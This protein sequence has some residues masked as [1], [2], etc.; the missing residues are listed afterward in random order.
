MHTVSRKQPKPSGQGKCE[1]SRSSSHRLDSSYARCSCTSQHAGHVR[2]TFGVVVVVT[3]LTECRNVTR[4]HCMLRCIWW[5]H[6]TFTYIIRV[7]VGMI[8]L[9]RAVALS[10]TSGLPNAGCT[11]ASICCCVT[12]G[13]RSTLLL[14]QKLLTAGI[15][16]EAQPK[17]Q[18]YTQS[19]LHAHARQ[20]RVRTA[21]TAP[22]CAQR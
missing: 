10:R 20:G 18:E 21:K 15:T 1:I 3:E 12:E 16:V 2:C 8:V 17:D 19:C 14:L 6:N 4:P 7:F 9:W 11:W 22:G 5:L 13:T